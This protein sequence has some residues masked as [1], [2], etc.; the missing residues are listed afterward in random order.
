MITFIKVNEIFCT[1]VGSALN[2]WLIRLIITCSD[3]DHSSSDWILL[4]NCVLEIAM[5]IISFI[6]QPSGAGERG[7][8]VMTQ[9]GFIDTHNEAIN[10]TLFS[11]SI[12]VSCWL[13]DSSAVQFVHRYLV[14][15][16][17][18]SVTFW[19]YGLMLCCGGSFSV[20]FIMVY[21]CFMIVTPYSAIEPFYANMSEEMST[22]RIAM[23]YP[24]GNPFMSFLT[25]YTLFLVAIR[26]TVVLSSG[27]L[28]W[29]YV[30]RELRNVSQRGTSR[31]KNLNFQ[32]TMAITGQAITPLLCNVI[33]N[34]FN[35]YSAITKTTFSFA[36]FLSVYSAVIMKWMPIMNATLTILIIK[37]YR[38]AFFPCRITFHR[39]GTNSVFVKSLSDRPTF[40]HAPKISPRSTM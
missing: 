37:K 35:C 26:Y 21:I 19:K 38:R 15:C 17:Q 16:K 4:Q 30:R 3:K 6:V 10:F 22:K 8:G 12:V 20:F 40:T 27:G 18:Q 31:S 29:M 1:I 28:T 32:V 24:Q 23:V 9:E 36:G 25:W 13:V 7:F 2:A 14:V 11:V 39:K 5:L 34:L 33:P